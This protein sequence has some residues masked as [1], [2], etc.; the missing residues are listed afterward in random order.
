MFEAVLV[1]A[2]I[3]KKLC[4]AVKDLVHDVN[5]N[6]D[7]NGIT[8]QAMDNTHVALVAFLLQADGFDKYRCDKNITLGINLPA[9]SKVLQCASND[10]TLT[11][12]AQDQP[13][14]LEL[15]FEN[16]TKHAEFNIKLLDLQVDPLGIPDTDYSSVVTMSSLEFQ[17]TTRDLSTIGDVDTVAIAVSEEGVKFAVSDTMNSQTGQIMIKNAGSIDGASITGCDITMSEPVE[18]SFA[19]HHINRFTKATSLSDKTTLSMSPDVPL[20]VEYA[21]QDTGYVRYYLAPK[22]DED[23]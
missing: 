13:D 7:S 22:I 5:F 15:I 10:D 6:C 2:E 21:I 4:A 9:L 11:M 14:N 23:N 17:R 12:R 3:L 8:L 16:K 19:L 1:K 20:V 18:M